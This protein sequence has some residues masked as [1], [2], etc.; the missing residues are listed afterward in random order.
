ME[1]EAHG[2]K[3]ESSVALLGL[4]K[5]HL[6]VLYGKIVTP[7][8][9]SILCFFSMCFHILYQIHSIVTSPKFSLDLWNHVPFFKLLS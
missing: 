4:I 3:T 9:N 1:Y 7:I 8:N 5:G 6:L 2:Y